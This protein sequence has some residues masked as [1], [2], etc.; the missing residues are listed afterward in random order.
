MG[1]EI[2]R[3]VQILPTAMA[4]GEAC[5][6]VHSASPSENNQPEEVYLVVRRHYDSLCK[7]IE[8]AGPQYVSNKLYAKG[9]VGSA[10]HRAL[11]ALGVPKARQ[12]ANI[13]DAF[14]MNLEAASGRQKQLK[15]LETFLEVIANINNSCRQKANEIA[16][17]N[18]LLAIKGERD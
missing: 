17:G 1:G 11:E 9:I 3:C 12:S 16:L 2:G 18:R 10:A 4:E 14:M 15:T 6:D 7:L 13:V 8:A 5:K